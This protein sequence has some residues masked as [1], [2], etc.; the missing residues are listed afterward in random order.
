[1]KFEV[2][3]DIRKARTIDSVVY[4]DRDIFELQKE[5]I[6]AGSWQWIGTE[7]L[8]PLPG[9]VSPFSLLPGFLD[10]PLL[11]VRDADDGIRC[12]SNVC[13]H[14]GNMLVRNAGE[15][16]QIVC[17]YHGRRFDLA[18]KFRHMPHFETVT[19]FPSPCDDLPVV[20][21]ESWRGHLFASLQP[22]YDLR[23]VFALLEQRLERVPLQ[24]FRFDQ[25]R[26]RDYLVQAN[27]AL[28]CE[29]YLEGFHI[30]FVHPELN[31]ALDFNSYTTELFDEGVLQIGYGKPGVRCFDLPASSPDYGKD[32]AA[33]Y[34]W[35]YPNMMFNFYPWGLS[36]NIVK[37]LAPMQCKVSF[38]TFIGDD[39]LI[40]NSAGTVLDKV[41][42][43][44]EFIVER[45]QAGVKSRLYNHGRYAPKMETGTHH[46]HRMMAASLNS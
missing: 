13:T 25:Q 7:A 27:W 26:S 35:V 32:V 42:R 5:K 23:K 6:F 33:Y 41:E 22:G 29:N 10:E 1:M 8:V 40:D 38:L 31:A 39:Q 14:R 46:F 4:S 12:I 19:D 20:S 11:L 28:Y 16:K 18:G 9:M 30:P 2:D 44:D 3:S 36:V 24:D 43:E 17:S 21:L 37:P 15:L 34:Y 45:T